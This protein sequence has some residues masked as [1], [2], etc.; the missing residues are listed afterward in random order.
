MK[1]PLFLAIVPV[2]FAGCISNSQHSE[3]VKTITFSSL[4]T[5]HYKHTLVTGMDFRESEE[6]MLEELSPATLIPELTTRGFN[7]VDSGGDFFVV[8]KWKKSV[9]QYPDMFDH[10]DGVRDSLDRRDHPSYQFASRLHL[11]VEIY[12]TSTGNLFWRKDLPNIFDAVQFTGERVI[13]S[14]QRAIENFPERVEEDSDL[15]DA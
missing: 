7:E 12:E 3:F 6:Q 4:Q 15:A 10:I 8:T 9:S 1:I 5:F 13:E 14:L 11:T 2:L